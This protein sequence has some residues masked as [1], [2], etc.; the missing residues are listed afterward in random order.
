MII[1]IN[2]ELRVTNVGLIY[3]SVWLVVNGL[4]LRWYSD[5]G[6]DDD[7]FLLVTVLNVVGVLYAGIC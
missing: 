4:R 6:G 5:C 2:N 1:S 3:F 7:T